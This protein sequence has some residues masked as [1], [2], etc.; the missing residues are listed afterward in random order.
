MRKINFL[1][2]VGIFLL[3]LMSAAQASYDV[4]LRNLDLY[5]SEVCSGDAVYAEVD[6]FADCPGEGAKSFG[7]GAKS[8]LLLPARSDAPPRNWIFCAITS[9]V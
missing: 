2:V 1:P 5:D 6:V 3:V 8:E 7:P 9:V 4:E